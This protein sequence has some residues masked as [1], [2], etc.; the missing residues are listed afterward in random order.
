[1]TDITRRHFALMSAIGLTA[2]AAPE[3]EVREITTATRIQAAEDLLGVEFTDA[4]RSQMAESLEQ[5]R[6][7]TAA[8]RTF[9][10]PNSLSPATVFDPRLP[11]VDYNRIEDLDRDSPLPAAFNGPPGMSIGQHLDFL[12]ERPFFDP[13]RRGV[14]ATDADLAFEGA[15]YHQALLFSGDISSERLTQLYLDRIDRHGPALECFVTVT[16]ELALEQARAAD[17][18]IRA[19]ERVP[20]LGI[21]YA[22][23][24]LFDTAGILTTY[25]A[26][27]FKTRVPDTD[28]WVIERL[29]EAGAVLLGKTTL[30]ALAY[31]DIWFGGRTN[32][33]WNPQEGSSGSSAGS[34]SAVAAGLCSFALGTE[35][36]GSLVSPSTRCGTA[37]LRPTFGL[38][39]RTGAMA[40]CWSMDKIGPIT[41]H[42]GDA[43]LI[44]PTLT[45]MDTGDPGS[46]GTLYPPRMS[47]PRLTV[48]YDPAWFTDADAG[49]QAALKALRDIADVVEIDNA[50]PADLP[51]GSLSNIL[52][53]EAAAAFEMLTLDG[54]DDTLAWQDDAA[55]PNTFRAARFITAIDLIQ[56]DRIRRLAMQRMHATF[57]RV[58]ALV[59]PPFAGGLLSVTN[60]TG[61]PCVTLRAGFSEQ[62]TRTLFDDSA[63]ESEERYR[64]P[65]SI[66]LWGG[67]FRDVDLVRLGAELERALGVAEERPAGFG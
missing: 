63:D 38:V 12:A 10:K 2:C 53:A 7:A 17:A 66:C 32:N 33:P 59:S 6:D 3:G 57:T 56:S 46:L 15:E 51:L 60:Y 37:T 49:Q 18:R 36:L 39:P 35:T 62:P 28:A 23:K 52:L 40:L 48:G 1:M 34:A 58:D 21:P 67:L 42:L 54:R 22:A 11:G 16:P 20:L 50:V 43:Q 61:H 24:D 44:M 19:G 31:G 26:E 65:N 45:G 29:R 41:R 27:P 64:V 5:S 25:G 4:E 47:K 9:D 13:P 30:G 14:P 8:L 55:W